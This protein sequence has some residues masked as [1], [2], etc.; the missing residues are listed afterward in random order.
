MKQHRPFFV[1]LVGE[2]Q[3]EKLQMFEPAA[4]RRR[5]FAI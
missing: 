1:V 4:F 5:V 3:R 2:A